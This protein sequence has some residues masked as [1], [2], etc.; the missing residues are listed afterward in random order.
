[1]ASNLGS[2]LIGLVPTILALG[3]TV[4]LIRTFRGK[5]FDFDSAHRTKAAA[6]KKATQ[7]RKRDFKTQVVKESENGKSLWVVYKRDE[8]G[9]SFY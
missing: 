1:M 5:D 3:I 8:S 4:A 2:S 7:L 9:F 6:D